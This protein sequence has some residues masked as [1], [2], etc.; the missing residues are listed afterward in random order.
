IAAHESAEDRIVDVEQD[1]D[2]LCPGMLAARRLDDLVFVSGLMGIDEE[3]L[4]A[5]ACKAPTAPYY[6]HSAGAQMTDVLSKAELILSAA[7]SSLDNVVRALHFQ[8]D[9]NTFPEVYTSWRN[10]MGDIGLP[11]SAIQVNP[12][13][14]VPDA[15]VIVDM[16]A[17]APAG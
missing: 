1:V 17:Y 11:F 3:G 8:K 5:G 7:G 13:L 14:F 12:S 2:L 9:L 10:K 16:I 4:I 15:E 6:D